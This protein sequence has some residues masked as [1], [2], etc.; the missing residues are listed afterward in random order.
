[1]LLSQSQNPFLQLRAD[2]ECEFTLQE[3]EQIVT[4][5][6][7]LITRL[8]S[9]VMLMWCDCDRVFRL[10]KRSDITITIQNNIVKIQNNGHYENGNNFYST[11]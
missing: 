6:T 9:F 7:P 4:Y 2:L 8:V 3:N 5:H 11:F 1:M 10:L